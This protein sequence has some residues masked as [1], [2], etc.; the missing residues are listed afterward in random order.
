MGV[1]RGLR[2]RKEHRLSVQGKVS[3]PKVDKATEECRRLHNELCSL[4]N[5]IRG[6]KFKKNEMY[7]ACDLHGERGDAY[8]VL[9]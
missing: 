7:W 1:K 3:G 6:D 8:R 2:L 4:P 9:R 5:F